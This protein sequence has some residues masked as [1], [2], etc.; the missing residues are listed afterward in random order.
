[1]K[2]QELHPW[3]VSLT[4]ARLIQ[5]GLRH[6]IKQEDI[7]KEVRFIAGADI[8]YARFS[9]EAY[10]GIVIM[11]WP[12]LEIVEKK[13]ATGEMQFPYVPGLLTFR[14]GP[15]LLR[16]WD[17]IEQEP[18]LI[19]FDGQGV[20]HPRG[21]GLA[22]HMGLILNTPSIGC[23]KKRLTGRYEEPGEERGAYSNLYDQEDTIIGAAV[24]TKTKTKV[25]FISVG[26][27][28]SMPSAIEWVFKCTKGYRV[29]EPLRQA[30][31]YVNQLRKGDYGDSP[32]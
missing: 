9:K 25:L 16:A 20:A 24:R 8:S 18:D 27:L 3:N 21:L 17:K 32:R 19:L 15:T 7:D 4:E 22:A 14:E 5:E 12:Q 23:A 26:N 31:M 28:I 6:K 1:M 30:H 10:A 13:G 11:N 29:T 2:Y